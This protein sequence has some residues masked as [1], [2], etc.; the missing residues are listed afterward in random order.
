VDRW[1]TDWERS[2]PDWLPYYTRANAGETLPDPASPLNW[3]FVWE[4]GFVPGWVR[5]MEDIGIYHQGQFP[6]EKPAQLGMFAGYFYIN[7]SHIRLM[8]LRLGVPVDQ[9]DLAFVGKRSDVPPYVPHPRDDD[10]ELTARA[11]A[12]VGAIFGRTAWPE[13]EERLDAARETRRN[14][15]D[16]GAMSDAELVSYARSFLPLLEDGWFWHDW[17][18][19]AASLGPG[20]LAATAAAVGRPE[21][22]LDLIAGIGDLES[23]SP[24]TGLWALSREVR[25]SEELTGLFG[26]G[27][28]A[29]I[30]ALRAPESD[31]VRSFAR[32]F[33]AFIAEHGLRGRN[34][35][36]IHSLTWEADPSQVVELVDSLRSADDRE[37]PAL[38]AGAQAERRAKAAEA[39]RALLSGD[40]AA[41]AQFEA[42]LASA[43]L[44][45]AAREQ[46]KL[47]CVIYLS[48]VRMAF[49]E[50]GRRGVEAGL[51]REPGDVM[52]LLAD[53]LD[54]YV[55]DPAA[56]AAVIAE[57]LEIYKSLFDIEPPF[58]LA[59]DPPPLA[60]WPRRRAADA[61][62]APSATE[63][64]VLTG[65]GGSSGSYTGTARVV[66]ELTELDRLEYG[67]V[68][69]APFTDAAWTPLFLVAGAVV[70]DLGAINSHAM[71]VAR[72]MGI[73]CVVSVDRASERI[74][75]GAM[76]TVDGTAGT[77]TIDSVPAQAPA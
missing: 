61:D 25:A 60:E 43:A 67:D 72:E 1:I 5:G 26:R 68:L 28:Q 48:E 19:L 69:V 47:L 59:G 27:T 16:L 51:Y 77:V 76:I 57:R 31:A 12:S 10:P 46:T 2:E 65:L 33:D 29:V 4:K 44:C 39:M 63:G 32:H 62:R 21:L 7:L 64:E 23:S 42:A 70:V 52:M 53:E 30:A 58:V 8:L 14:R 56:F 36:D 35:W 50:L 73:P 13:V 18:T 75:D 9:V 66:S 15:P 11:A 41:T 45:V 6:L 37:D 55:S 20:A 49:L 40:D 3:S 17:T 22:G 38:R 24:S 54:D 34:E 74:P 71:V